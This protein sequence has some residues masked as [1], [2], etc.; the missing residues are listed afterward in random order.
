MARFGAAP[1]LDP[2]EGIH[3]RIAREM[4]RGGDWMGRPSLVH[5]LVQAGGRRLY[6]NRW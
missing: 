1:F 4:L 5:L 3:A 6:S 2:P